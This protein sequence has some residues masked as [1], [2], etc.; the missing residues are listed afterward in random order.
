MRYLIIVI[1]AFLLNGFLFS[2]DSLIQN[3]ISFVP[4]SLF[5]HSIRVDY[6]K[7][8]DDKGTKYLIVS[9]RVYYKEFYNE[10]NLNIYSSNLIQVKGLGLELAY[11]YYFP[12]RMKHY[13]PFISLH[14]SYSYFEPIYQR[15]MWQE[16]QEDENTFYEFK[17]GTEKKIIHQPKLEFNMGMLRKYQS[18]IFYD[19]YLGAGIKQSFYD[20]VKGDPEQLQ[21]YY[22]SWGYS[23]TYLNIGFRLGFGW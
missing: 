13:F 4:Q 8:M 18:K 21:L 1:F 7:C 9:P 22:W 23:G 20:R 16:M 12:N 17:L 15:Y 6:D 3:R 2:Q 10:D 19:I 14:A 5:F 11:R